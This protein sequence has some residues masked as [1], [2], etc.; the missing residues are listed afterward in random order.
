MTRAIHPAMPVPSLGCDRAN[1]EERR[2]GTLTPTMSS[3]FTCPRTRML[4][5]FRTVCVASIPGE[6]P[7]KRPKL[8]P[9]AASRRIV[10]SADCC[11]EQPF[12]PGQLEHSL[13]LRRRISD[14]EGGTITRTFRTNTQHG[15]DPDESMNVTPLKSNTTGTLKVDTCAKTFWSSGA[16]S[17]SIFPVTAS[18]AEPSR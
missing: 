11:L 10:C 12:Q 3:A 9:S 8:T 7:L 17:M 16:V 13:H 4:A 6:H 5:W 14:D 15:F 1:S 18:S 2:N